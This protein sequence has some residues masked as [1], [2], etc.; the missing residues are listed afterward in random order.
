MT[1]LETATGLK[2][3][4][5]HSDRGGEFIDGN[6][7]S[8]FKEKGIEHEVSVPHTPQQNG[9]AEHFNQTTHEHALA[10]LHDVKLSMGFWPE[11]HKYT[12]YVRNHSP[13]HALSQTTP[14]EAFHGR[15]PN[16]ASLCIFGSRCHVCI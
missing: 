2:V 1:R 11:A 6:I 9:V 14:N 12:L 10:M 8:F 4:K 13:T 5:V 16:V 3:K 15:K 7:Q